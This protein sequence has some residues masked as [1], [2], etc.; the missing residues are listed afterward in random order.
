MAD[1]L[2]GGR[3]Q[4]RGG[5]AV[6]RP[7][8]T[9]ASC[10][11]R[12]MDIDRPRSASERSVHLRRVRVCRCT[13]I[14]PRMNACI[15]PAASRCTRFS[16]SP[17]LECCCIRLFTAVVVYQGNKQ[18]VLLLPVYVYVYRRLYFFDWCVVAF[19]T[20]RPHDIIM[21]TIIARPPS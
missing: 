20:Y 17:S 13:F 10:V 16:F 6:G 19:A 5:N 12:F 1:S 11:E 9:R 18:E 2:R 3:H 15:H 14:N 7:T 8:I 21:N 4:I